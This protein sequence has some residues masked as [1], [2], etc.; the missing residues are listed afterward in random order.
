MP[1]S[2]VTAAWA[3]PSM[4]TARPETTA[5]PAFA[6]AA[7]I[8]AAVSRPASGRP[9]GADDGDCVPRREGGHVAED[10][11]HV[12]RHL[13]RPEPR[14]V[15]L[16]VERQDVDTGRLDPAKHRIRVPR[17]L[18]DRLGRRAIPNVSRPSSMLRRRPA[19]RRPRAGPPARGSRRPV[20]NRRSSAPNPTGP[21][22]TTDTR[23][24]Q[25]SRSL[26]PGPDREPD[27][28]LADVRSS[29][30]PT[31]PDRSGGPD[32]QHS[33]RLAGAE[34]RG[35]RSEAGGFLEMPAEHR[36]APRPGPRSSGRRAGAAPCRGR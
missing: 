18:R 31:S 6:I 35:R 24:A 5:A 16:V 25:A 27:G 30:P 9:A 36:A 14:R 11:E 32:A 10:E 33:A 26:R 23:T 17:E 8:R 34:T 12:R 7:P 1:C 15:G 2:A 21:S 28:R 29:S 22:P 20:P 3:A 4:P 13:D 19:P